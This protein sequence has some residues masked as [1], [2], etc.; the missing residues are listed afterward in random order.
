MQ[1]VDQK[2]SGSEFDTMKLLGFLSWILGIFKMA[3]RENIPPKD[4]IVTKNGL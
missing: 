1:P 2:E 3:K 4:N